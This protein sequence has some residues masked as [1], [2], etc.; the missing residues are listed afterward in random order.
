MMSSITKIKD[1]LN[2]QQ[3]IFLEALFENGG[4]IAAAKREA[5]YTSSTNPITISKKLQ[6]A[7]LEEARLQLALNTPKAVSKMVGIF[8]DPTA[9]GTDKI[10][11]TAKQILDRVGIVKK[12]QI[13]LETNMPNAILILPPKNKED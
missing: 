1:E 9:L 12:E 13:E 3:K 8:D 11:E 4:N 10:L 5:G 6:D 7:I 2:P